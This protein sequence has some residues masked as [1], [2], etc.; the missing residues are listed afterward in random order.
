MMY[1]AHQRFPTSIQQLALARQK[2]LCASC[3]T[4]I[5]GVGESGMQSHQFGE[6]AEGHHVVPHKLG[7][8]I[9]LENCVILCR[10]CH[11]SSHQG[12]RWRDVSIYADIARLPMPRKIAK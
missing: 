3:G 7:G 11:M 2:F 1:S 9:T 6:R 5:S 12:A 4:H 8:P 10:S